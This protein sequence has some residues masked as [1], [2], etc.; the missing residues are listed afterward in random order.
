MVVGGMRH[1][2]RERDPPLLLSERHA[3]GQWI[4]PGAGKA[5]RARMCVCR[6]GSKGKGMK[7][8]KVFMDHWMPSDRWG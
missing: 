3:Q 1:G 6:G 7:K 5:N 2:G 8:Q 4:V